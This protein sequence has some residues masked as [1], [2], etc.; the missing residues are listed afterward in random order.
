MADRCLRFQLGGSAASLRHECAKGEKPSEPAGEE[1]T[2]APCGKQTGNHMTGRPAT[3][4]SSKVSAPVMT[5][6]LPFRFARSEAFPGVMQTQINT[7]VIAIL[8]DNLFN[9]P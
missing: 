3:M 9:F 2:Y 8:F 4:R 1:R 6:A 7:A 5:G